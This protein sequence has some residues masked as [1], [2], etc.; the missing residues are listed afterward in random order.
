VDHRA[1]RATA[2]QRPELLPDV[3][4]YGL[5]PAVEKRTVGLGYDRPGPGMPGGQ[6]DLMLSRVG[7]FGITETASDAN[8]T[9]GIYE[10]A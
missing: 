7:D 3:S 8:E 9:V 5:G 2:G 1:Y 6:Q 10:R 4:E